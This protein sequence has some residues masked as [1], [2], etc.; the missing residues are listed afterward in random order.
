MEY[1]EN[2][3]L[4]VD[5]NIDIQMGYINSY[6]ESMI[7]E[8]PSRLINS[9]NKLSDAGIEYETLQVVKTYLVLAKNVTDSETYTFT[10][11][12]DSKEINKLGKR[13]AYRIKDLRKA[14]EDEYKRALAG[15]Q[16][17]TPTSPFNYIFL[18]TVSDT[19]KKDIKEIVEE[20]KADFDNWIEEMEK[21][22]NPKKEDGV[23]G[24]CGFTG[25]KY[26]Y[27]LESYDSKLAYKMALLDLQDCVFRLSKCSRYV[28]Y[29][30]I[31]PLRKTGL[32]EGKRS[33][34]AVSQ[35]GIYIVNFIDGP[36]LA[37]MTLDET[38]FRIINYITT[39]AIV[40]G[41]IGNTIASKA[42]GQ[43]MISDICHVCY[44]TRK[45]FTMKDY[46]TVYKKLRRISEVR[47]QKIE[48]TN[49]THTKYKVGSRTIALFDDFDLPPELNFEEEEEQQ[50]KKPRKRKGEAYIYKAVLGDAI[51]R[52]TI[53]T[54]LMP[55]LSAP[56][57]LLNDHLAHL[58]YMNICQD[59]VDDLIK[60]IDTHIYTYIDMQLIARLSETKA[61]RVKMYLEALEE[62]RDKNTIIKEV[63]LLKAE[64]KFFV[65]WIPLN[66]AERKDIK[67]L[68]S[69]ENSIMLPDNDNQ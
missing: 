5:E 62:M 35:D 21:T 52:A 56:M 46:E 64:E 67:I 27:L 3:S 41:F 11:N 6:T 17:L 7:S 43:G 63:N 65:K 40:N 23:A 19:S 16:F 18:R 59:R 49:K 42:S 66:E 58:I 2:T 57:K 1:S 39:Q 68:G 34:K 9:I 25:Y 51:K 22:K 61:K 15:E 26:F 12:A 47:F 10:Q 31:V 29:S 55:V 69:V 48:Y 53:S 8:L 13:I 33:L 44:P 28:E 20:I 60:G 50:E 36:Y 14:V 45:T 37:S 24:F 30:N 4:Y 32:F 54:H 38:E